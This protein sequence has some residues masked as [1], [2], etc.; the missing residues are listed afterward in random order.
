MTDVEAAG[1]SRG[2][3]VVRVGCPSGGRGGGAVAVR[4]WC[5]AGRSGGGMS[6]PD[7]PLIRPGQGRGRL[8]A[9]S[10]DIHCC[11]AMTSACSGLP[12]RD[13]G[14]VSA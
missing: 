6:G 5:G 7:R 3:A 12:C 4:R 14:V 10:S 1:G 13:H 11:R 2:K 8:P 9:Q